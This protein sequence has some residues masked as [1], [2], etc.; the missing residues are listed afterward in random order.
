MT[1]AAEKKDFYDEMS[2]TLI[3]VICQIQQE[4]I[5]ISQQIKKMQQINQISKFT[6]FWSLE[7]DDLLKHEDMIY[8]FLNSALTFFFLKNDM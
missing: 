5:F 1:V 8:I 4:N 6:V 7:Q 3:F 2:E